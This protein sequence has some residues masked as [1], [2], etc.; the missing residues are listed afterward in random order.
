ML[1]SVVKTDFQADMFKLV[2]V[3]DF[4]TDSLFLKELRHPGSNAANK[5][6]SALELVAFN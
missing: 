4:L 1:L 5:W 6:K 3:Y 2:F